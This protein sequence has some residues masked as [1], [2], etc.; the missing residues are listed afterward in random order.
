MEPEGAFIHMFWHEPF[1]EF[2]KGVKAALE[3][4][5]NNH[6]FCGEWCPAKKWKD[7]ERKLKEL[8]Y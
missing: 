4:H 7:D 1:K 8:K 2:K 3:H 6:E 5:F